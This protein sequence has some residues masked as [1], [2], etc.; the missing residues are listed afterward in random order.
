L[1][2][3]DRAPAEGR[4]HRGDGGGGGPRRGDPG[5][6]G[7]DRDSHLRPQVAQADGTPGVCD[8]AVGWAKAHANTEQPLFTID[9]VRR[10]H[11]VRAIGGPAA[12]ARR[13]RARLCPPYGADRD[14][15]RFHSPC[16]SLVGF[17]FTAFR[18]RGRSAG[19]GFVFTRRPPP[20]S[21]RWVRF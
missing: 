21:P 4:P 3:R 1:D 8:R 5:C 2:R 18:P 6:G 19:F 16:A 14:W 13:A 11:A 17:V 7:R 9:S 15:V 20:S 12:W 10:A